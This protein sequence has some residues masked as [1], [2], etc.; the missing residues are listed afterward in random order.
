MAIAVLLQLSEDDLLS[1]L[2]QAGEKLGSTDGE[3]VLDFSAVDRIDPA[4]I[5]AMEDLAGVA[6]AAGVKLALRGV[7][8]GVYKV[9]KLAKLRSQF[10]FLF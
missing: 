9:L 3:M 4:A 2:R 1:G 10:T 8:I 6:Q 5:S 7:N